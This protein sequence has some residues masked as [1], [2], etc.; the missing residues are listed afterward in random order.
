MC[1]SKTS[2][3]AHGIIP[4]IVLITVVLVSCA[5]GQVNSPATSAPATVVS[6]VDEVSLDLVV[7]NEKNKPVLDLKAEDVAVLDNGT[8]VKIT[9]LRLVPATSGSQR[10]LTLVFDRLDA[11]T[12]TNARNIAWKILKDIPL[13]KF[14]F[15]VLSIDGRL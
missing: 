12:A 8:P 13:D 14:S 11:A 9:D 10:L 15:S 3:Q 6:N 5:Y 1:G 4:T 7:H 2:V